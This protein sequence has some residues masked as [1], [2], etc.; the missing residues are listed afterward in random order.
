MRLQTLAC[1]VLV[2]AF[3]LLLVTS[4]ASAQD[5]AVSSAD[6]GQSVPQHFQCPTMDE[7]IKKCGGGEYTKISYNGCTFVKCG[8]PQ[9]AGQPDC[10]MSKDDVYK[11]ALACKQDHGNPIVQTVNGSCYQFVRCDPAKTTTSKAPRVEPPKPVECRKMN[12]VI[13]C[14][15]GTSYA[16]QTCAAPA[17][18]KTQPSPSDNMPM[19]PTASKGPCTDLEQQ[20]KNAYM[21]ASQN[22]TN[23]DLQQKAAALR[24]KLTDCRS[25]N[26]VPASSPCTVAPDPANPG[27]Y[28][29]TCGNDTPQQIC[30][31]TLGDQ[32]NASACNIV[33]DGNCY[34]KICGDDRKVVSKSCRSTS[35]AVSQ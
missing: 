26:F 3:P 24:S 16:A 19:P 35:A 17:V 13:R 12:G 9:A 6:N 10:A 18:S 22:P 33:V 23:S 27:C 4:L 8:A 20:F 7:Q 14:E 34:L 32:S 1:G 2:A 29:K 28:L 11:K 25:N 21:Q 30:A 31:Q 5:S 15:D